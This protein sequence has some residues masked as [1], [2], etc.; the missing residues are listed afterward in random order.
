MIPVEWQGGKE[1]MN[2]IEIMVDEHKYITR[3]LA[4]VR[5]ACIRFMNKDEICY[6]DFYDMIDFIR[7][8]SDAHHHGK[9]EKFLF[10]EMEDRIDGIGTKLIRNG[11]LVEHDFGRLYITQLVE[12]IKDYK[13]GNIERK[14]DIIANAISYTHLLERHIA[15]EDEVIYS[16]GAKQ[17][18]KEVM[19]DINKKSEVFETE[20]T[21]KG[22]QK[23]YIDSLIRLE[24]IY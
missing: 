22:T 12:A 13:S 24:G 9:E 6:E 19:D 16:F 5:N 8:Y 11:M 3:M 4:V 21:L 1:P 7:S 2:S 14:I 15:K 18:S 20:A 23:K 17:L 10:K